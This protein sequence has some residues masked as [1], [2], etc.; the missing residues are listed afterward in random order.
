M[1]LDHIVKIL[2]F[3][4]LSVAPMR[5][6]ANGVKHMPLRKTI[7]TKEDLGEKSKYTPSGDFRPEAD[8]LK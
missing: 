7:L 6:D 4:L 3:E 1:S 8:S 2:Y 5:T